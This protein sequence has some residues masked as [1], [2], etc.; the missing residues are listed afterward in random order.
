LAKGER[1]AS[2]RSVAL[3]LPGQANWHKLC[4]RSFQ[5]DLER[6]GQAAQ[7]R[8][9]TSPWKKWGNLDFS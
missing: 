1:R 5:R 8:N 2:P 4:W 9:T 6:P 7:L 3:G